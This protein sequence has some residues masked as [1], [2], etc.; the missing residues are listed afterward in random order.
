M[1]KKGCLILTVLF[2]ALFLLPGGSGESSSGGGPLSAEIAERIQEINSRP[3][4][5]KLGTRRPPV[6]EEG[7]D[8][9]GDGMNSDKNDA[10]SL[11]SSLGLDAVTL[12]PEELREIEETRKVLKT[13]GLS[14]ADMENALGMMERQKKMDRLGLGPADMAKAMMKATIAGRGKGAA[15]ITGSPASTFAFSSGVSAPLPST[16]ARHS[17]PAERENSSSSSPMARA[18]RQ[19]TSQLLLTCP[20]GAAT[21]LTYWMP[22]YP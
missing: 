10:D 8:R 13:S 20:G 7:A 22:R 1:G 12:D 11:F 18:S 14:E 16:S 5:G 9:E 21:G 19:K 15:Q 17:A 4:A 2:A 6:T 3:A